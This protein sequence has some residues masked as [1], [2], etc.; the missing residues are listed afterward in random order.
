MRICLFTSL[1]STTMA[2][3]PFSDPV[4]HNA[5]Q[6]QES[7]GPKYGNA[8]EED[9]MNA[10]Q[11]GGWNPQ[12]KTEAH[13]METYYSADPAASSQSPG[14]HQQQQQQPPAGDAYQQGGGFAHQP[15]DAY[16]FA[17]TRYA[18]QADDHAASSPSTATAGG[19]SGKHL[20]SYSRVATH[21]RASK[22]TGGNA[23]DGASA[24]AAVAHTG[25]PSVKRLGIRVAQLVAAVGHL[26]FAA[27]ASP[28]SYIAST[29]YTSLIIIPLVF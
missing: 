28:V 7:S 27:G 19:D 3:N 21:E 22:Q 5:W 4:T 17:G 24:T 26:G 20:S 25:R 12:E 6:Q 11:G 8:Y 10:W 18:N 29:C 14:Y 9:E 15:M 23:H 2:Q 1:C 13:P 16:Q